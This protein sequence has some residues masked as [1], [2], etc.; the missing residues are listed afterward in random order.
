MT[1]VAQG[2]LEWKR[3]C[4]AKN[5]SLDVQ[6]WLDRFYL[7]RIGIRFL[8]G[9][10]RCLLCAGEVT[11]EDRAQTLLLTPCNLILTTLA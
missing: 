3:S 6:T 10:R 1:T 4:N 11:T 8:I 2:V 9:Q 5:I 7:S